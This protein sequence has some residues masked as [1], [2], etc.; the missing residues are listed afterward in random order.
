M[1]KESPATR[2]EDL[3]R[4][5]LI[6]IEKRWDGESDRKRANAISPRME[7]CITEAKKFINRPPSAS[8]ISLPSDGPGL[9]ATKADMAFAPSE[10]PASDPLAASGKPIAPQTETPTLAQDIADGKYTMSPETSAPSA[11]EPIINACGSRAL[12]ASSNTCMGLKIMASNTV[13][14]GEVHIRDASGKLVGKIINVY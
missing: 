4:E 13:P 12:Y 11:I 1:T 5:L 8:A 2:G 7:E 10:T 9:L 14:A 6:A 3:L